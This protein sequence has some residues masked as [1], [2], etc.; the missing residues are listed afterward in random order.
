[1]IETMDLTHPTTLAVTD[2]SRAL[3]LAETDDPETIIET[4]P[5]RFAIFAQA[6]S[7]WVLRDYPA[8][9]DY[10]FLTKAGAIAGM[11]K[12]VTKHMDYLGSPIKINAY[13]EPLEGIEVFA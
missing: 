7:G 9:R 1:M 6:D 3:S 2:L 5:A 10:P 11:E 8:D 4:K 13:G 12:R